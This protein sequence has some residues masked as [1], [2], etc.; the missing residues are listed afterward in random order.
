MF[1]GVDVRSAEGAAAM[2]DETLSDGGLVLCQ[3]ELVVA[4]L[5]GED[6]VITP[7]VVAGALVVT[8]IDESTIELRWD[9]AQTL[10]PDEEPSYDDD[11]SLWLRA[12]VDR[13]FGE[14]VPI[15]DFWNHDDRLFD[16]VEGRRLLL[17]EARQVRY[18]HADPLSEDDQTP[19]T[20]Q[21][22]AVAVWLGE[23]GF[24]EVPGSHYQTWRRQ[25]DDDFA[26]CL[27]L[28]PRSLQ[29]EQHGRRHPLSV[30]L[31]IASR[32]LN[33]A[34]ASLEDVESRPL[35]WSISGE[36]RHFRPTA[37]WSYLPS[38]APT[39]VVEDIAVSIDE[40]GTWASHEGVHRFLSADVPLRAETWRRTRIIAAALADDHVGAETALSEWREA[41]QPSRGFPNELAKRLQHFGDHIEGWLSDFNG[42]AKT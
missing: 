33:E 39:K 3:G 9:E 6:Y 15:S 11:E 5:Q 22:D 17:T 32:P 4:D 28:T 38:V 24:S 41:L 18:D 8:N 20:D 25:V 36:Q 34:L 37:P 14:L 30:Q 1:R 16:M 2:L 27:A 7:A 10:H 42:E 23:N 26:L 31:G 29:G 40:L 19:T 21:L 12:I 13:E 35:R